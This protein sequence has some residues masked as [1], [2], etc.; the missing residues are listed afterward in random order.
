MWSCHHPASNILKT[1][2]RSS[3][4]NW[5]TSRWFDIRGPLFLSSS[6]W[7]GYCAILDH[8]GE[9]SPLVVAEQLG[10]DLGFWW[11]CRAEAQN[12]CRPLCN[13]RI[14]FSFIYNSHHLHQGPFCKQLTRM[15]SNT[16]SFCEFLNATYLFFRA[17]PG[18]A[19]DYVLVCLCKHFPSFQMHSE[20]PEVRVHNCSMAPHIY[21]QCLAG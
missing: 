7:L 10:R 16:L 6:P 12:H 2:H 17:F 14:M 8:V 18:V 15:L 1:S 9:G 3:G 20:V 21:S 11:Q 19:R 4:N 13:R 5:N